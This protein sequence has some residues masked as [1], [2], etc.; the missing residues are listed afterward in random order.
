MLTP[1][2]SISLVPSNGTPAIFRVLAS[3]VDVSE[4]KLDPEIISPEI[5]LSAKLPTAADAPSAVS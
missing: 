4:F 2:R 5:I 3:F 1:G